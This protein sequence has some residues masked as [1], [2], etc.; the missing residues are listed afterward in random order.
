MENQLSRMVSSV[1][2][3]REQ[4]LCKRFKWQLGIAK[5][6]ENMW[7]SVSYSQITF[8]H[9]FLPIQNHKHGKDLYIMP[10]TYVQY[11]CWQYIW[12]SPIVAEVF[13]ERFYWKKYFLWKKI[14]F[15]RKN[16]RQLK[17]EIFCEN[18]LLQILPNQIF[19]GCKRL[20]IWKIWQN[21]ESFF[22]EN[23][24]LKFMT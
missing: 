13:L 8:L 17:A 15:V 1:F 5:L 10:K 12:R 23:I 4:T 3:L 11:I 22:H 7:K 16:F 20:Q 6:I 2:L 18:R 19:C 24:F 9:M 21:R 14:F